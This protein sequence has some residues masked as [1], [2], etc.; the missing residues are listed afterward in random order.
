[1]QRSL[2]FLG[3]IVDATG[4]STDPDKVKAIV[5]FPQPQS[6]RALRR[7]LGMV[8]FYRRF[9]P[10]CADLLQPLTDM[11]RGQPRTSSAPLHWS[12]A[13]TAAFNRAKDAICNITTLAHPLPG[14]DVSLQVDASNYAVGA[15]LQQC[16]DGIWQPLAF[17][18]K[19]LEPAES[20]YSTFGRELLAMYL[21]VKHFRFF[22]EARPFIIFTDHKPLT[23]A[24]KCPSSS[25]SP[26]ELRH[27]SYIAEFTSAIRHVSGVDNVVAGALSRPSVNATTALSPGSDT[28]SSLDFAKLA[29][30]QTTC[31]AFAALRAR[32]DSSLVFGKM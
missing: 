23:F 14:G 1:M 22:Q 13:A 24:I 4:I 10:H 12:D 29:R 31:E 25:S 18:S 26:R 30:A 19:R 11:T 28:A 21:S 17:F 2:S 15:V 9:F 8:N 16:V 6:L 20:R 32:T 27:L 5:E 3:H 7:F